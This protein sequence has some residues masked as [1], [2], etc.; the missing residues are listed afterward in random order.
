MPTGD[1]HE[2]FV[3]DIYSEVKSPWWDDRPV[4]IVA[5]GP[6]LRGFDWE[7][8]RGYHVLAVKGSIFDIPWADAGFGLDMPRFEEWHEKLAAVTMPVYWAVPVEQSIITS[9]PSPNMIFL[10]RLIGDGVSFDPTMI[11]GGGTSGYGSVQ[12]AMLKHAKRIMLYGFDF[13]PTVTGIHAYNNRALTGFRHNDKH[14]G[15]RRMQNFANW[16]QWAKNF[17]AF[18]EPCALRGIEIV[19]AS[20]TSGIPTFKRVTHEESFEIMRRW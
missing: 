9:R 7:R 15:K 17:D 3:P 12:I 16:Q 11:Y 4:A 19:N 20:P 10:K 18:R 1:L 14:Y 2:T 5:G 13:N 8:L 6:S